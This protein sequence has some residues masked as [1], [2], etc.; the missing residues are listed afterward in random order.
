MTQEDPL[1]EYQASQRRRQT[2]M[3]VGGLLVGLFVIVGY[4][5]WDSHSETIVGW[6]AGENDWTGRRI[7]E[8]EHEVSKQELESIDFELVHEKLFP[9]WLSA[10]SYDPPGKP[11]ERTLERYKKLEE[12]VSA[13][14]NL[15]A[16]LEELAAIVHSEDLGDRSDRALY[17]SWAWSNY[18]DRNGQPWF[19]DGGVLFRRKGPMFYGKF[20]YQLHGIDVRV[21]GESYRGRLLR[22]ADMTNVR[23]NY[24]GS[25]ST[26]EEG[27]MVV[28][29]RVSDFVADEIW[30]MLDP[31]ADEQLNPLQKA[32][33]PAIR[34]EAAET[35]PAAQLAVLRETAS[36]RLALL[37]V[38]EAV[39]DRRDC[40]D[41]RITYRPEL[42]YPARQIDR[43][44]ARAM[45]DQG[46][47]CPRVTMQEYDTL[48][49]A[50]AKFQTIDGMEEALGALT[51]WVT[52]GVMVHEAKHVADDV[53]FD[54][55]D[56]PLECDGCPQNMGTSSRAE[57]SAYL[58]SFGYG[59][60][61]TVNLFQ[62]CQVY[63][64]ARGAHGFALQHI[65]EPL[66]VDGECENGPRDDFRKR[67]IEMESKLL[68]R[69]DVI[70]LPESYPDVVRLRLYN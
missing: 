69:T 24:L 14:P 70:E 7:Y 56:E 52:R 67:V 51:A 46:K 11:S 10:H 62:A 31:A 68:G 16:I 32:F 2:T 50:S 37:Q 8:P 21:D 57:M 27:A 4:Q 55:L 66:V 18:L 63:P 42:G 39:N 20:Y 54:A 41:F 44:E 35:I 3:L 64:D 43:L 28:L 30:T 13:D 38:V 60:A 40:S 36:E 15:S 65:L 45:A 53:R 61:R 1:S 58:S 25:A 59:A 26:A 22:R 47:D 17:L 5:I 9:R 29:D 19:V 12:A 6:F 49:V 48:N 34:A 23:E 33:A